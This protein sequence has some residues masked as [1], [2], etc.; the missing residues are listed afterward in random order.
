MPSHIFTRLA[1]WDESIA[2]NIA[3]RDAAL[4]ARPEDQARLLRLRPAPRPRLPGVCLPAAGPRRRRG[5]GAR[6]RSPRWT[7][8]T[9]RTSPPPTPWPRCPRATPSNDGTGAA[10]AAL[11]VRPATLPLGNVPLRRGP[12]ALRAGRGRRAR[13]EPAAAARDGLTRLAEIKAALVEAKDSFWAGQVEIQR[14]AA[15]GWIARAE[16]RSTTPARFP[17][18]RGRPRGHDRQA[19]GDAGIGAAGA[20][21]AGRPAPRARRAAGRPCG[22]TRPRSSPCPAASTAW[23]A[24]FA[25]RRR[26]ATCQGRRAL[27]R[28]HRP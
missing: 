25:P 6:A 26:R 3:S 21:D 28:A 24:G 12:R 9:C 19:S 20:R 15:E 18:C 1:L 5:A 2:S 23:P 13:G 4:A 8:S 10:A 11:T 22:S 16:G 27:H 7:S 14:L 17:A